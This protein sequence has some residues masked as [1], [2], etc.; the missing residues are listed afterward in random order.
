MDGKAEG[1][2]TEAEAQSFA[3]KWMEETSIMIASSSL[4]IGYNLS[5]FNIPFKLTLELFSLAC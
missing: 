3:S 2:T 1:G 4:L 5:F